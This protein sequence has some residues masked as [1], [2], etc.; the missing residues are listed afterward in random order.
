MIPV[1]RRCAVV[2]ALALVLAACA[3]ED[4]DVALSI[5]D[6]E[7]TFEEMSDYQALVIG[8]PADD[9]SLDADAARVAAA[10]W[11]RAAGQLEAL[12]QAGIGPTNAELLD[13]ELE[14]NEQIERGVAP[15]IAASSPIYD[16]II[17]VLAVNWI[18]RVRAAL[19]DDAARNDVFEVLS[20]HLY[21]SRR[22]GEWDDPV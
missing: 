20:D 12:E 8:Q 1:L 2:I 16:D 4:R 7:I 9:G 14:L 18:D 17:D 19:S 21:V 10:T 3:E 11:I 13:V 22:L 15:P 5:G 6:R